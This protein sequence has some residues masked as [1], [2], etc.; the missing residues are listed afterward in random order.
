M[1]NS[2]NID[3][4]KYVRP[5]EAEIKANLTDEQYLQYFSPAYTNER[6]IFK[7]DDLIQLARKFEI[8]EVKASLTKQDIKQILVQYL[9]DKDILEESALI[10]ISKNLHQTDVKL[11]ELELKR[12]ELQNKKEEKERRLQYDREREEKE[13]KPERLRK[14]NSVMWVMMRHGAIKRRVG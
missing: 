6:D 12:L 4:Q 3:T 10:S 7:K 13:R 14:L 1:A 5:S 8:S 2:I 11:N 9:V